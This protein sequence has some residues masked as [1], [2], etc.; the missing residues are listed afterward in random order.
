MSD[1]VWHDCPAC[2]CLVTDEEQHARF[3]STIDALTAAQPAGQDG[4]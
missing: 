2:G 1:G 3:H 4:P